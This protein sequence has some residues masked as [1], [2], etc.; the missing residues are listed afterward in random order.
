MK[1]TDRYGCVKKDVLPVDEGETP[2]AQLS[3]RL[4]FPRGTDGSIVRLIDAPE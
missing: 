4:A 3:P 2:R 1:E